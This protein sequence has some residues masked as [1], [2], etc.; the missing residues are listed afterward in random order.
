MLCN[1]HS[2]AK[3]VFYVCV[4]SV[5]TNKQISLLC[6]VFFFLPVLVTSCVGGGDGGSG[7]GGGGGVGGRTEGNT[8]VVSNIFCMTTFLLHIVLK[9]EKSILQFVLFICCRT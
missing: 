8:S 3:G 5:V 7:G 9:I 4:S 1:I 2:E 6:H